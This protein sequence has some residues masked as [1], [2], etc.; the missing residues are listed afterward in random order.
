MALTADQRKQIVAALQQDPDNKPTYQELAWSFGTSETSIFRA[1]VE[2]RVIKNKTF[3]AQW[4][5]D[6]LQVL[7]A[8]GLDDVNKLSSFIRKAKLNEQQHSEA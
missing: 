5:R 8:H 4:E 6:L 3:K 7:E 2:E 1:L